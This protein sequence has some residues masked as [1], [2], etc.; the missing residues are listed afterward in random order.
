MAQKKKTTSSAVKKKSSSR[1]KKNQTAKITQRR[2][3]QL[4]LRW[5]V[6]S[7]L[8]A[9]LTFFS[10]LGVEGIG[11]KAVGDFIRSMLGVGFV[12]LPF[13]L[14]LVSTLLIICRGRPFMP[15]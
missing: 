7:A 3:A 12:I 15:R 11:L 14:V 13:S 8:F 9:L 1:A 5:A 6:V 10:L 4:N 2:R